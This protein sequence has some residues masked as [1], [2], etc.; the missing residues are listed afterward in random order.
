MIQLFRNPS[1][2]HFCHRNTT[3]FPHIKDIIL[4]SHKLIVIGS[5][6][7][8]SLNLYIQNIICIRYCLAALSRTYSERI[9]F[10]FCSSILWEYNTIIDVLHALHRDFLPS[11]VITVCLCCILMHESMMETKGQIT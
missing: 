6:Q 8:L 3:D 2:A 10:C 7:L 9:N 5:V 1:A 4:L 11:S